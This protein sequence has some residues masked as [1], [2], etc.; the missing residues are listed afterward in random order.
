[1]RKIKRKKKVWLP[2]FSSCSFF[3]SFFFNKNQ[4]KENHIMP[5]AFQPPYAV[6]APGAVKKEGETVPYRHF[7]FAD[8]L[9]DHPE[10]IFTLWDAFNNGYN[11][12]G[13]E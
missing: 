3:L 10:N 11:L 1:M 12:A 5:P 6:P 4:Y 13:G 2:L 8:K 9:I 7:K